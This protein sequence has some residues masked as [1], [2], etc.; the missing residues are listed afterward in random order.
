MSRAEEEAAHRSQETSRL[1]VTAC[2]ENTPGGVVQREKHKRALSVMLPGGQGVYVCVCVCLFVWRVQGLKH[3]S[4]KERVVGGSACHFIR[5]W[6]LTLMCHVQKKKKKTRQSQQIDLQSEQE[7]R[8]RGRNCSDMLPLPIW[9]HFLP[10]TCWPFTS[11]PHW[12]VVLA[13]D[14]VCV[15]LCFYHVT[16]VTNCCV[17]ASPAVPHGETQDFKPPHTH[18]SYKLSSDMMMHLNQYQ[19]KTRLAPPTEVHDFH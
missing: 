8:W 5:L 11:S 19:S 6:Q 10:A 1:V 15:R 14:E 12:D 4:R 9:D 3:W 13:F 16:S 18:T 7:K 17:A 2:L